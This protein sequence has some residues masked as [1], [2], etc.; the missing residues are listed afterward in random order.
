MVRVSPL[1]AIIESMSRRN[2]HKDHDFATIA[3]SVVEQ[4]IGEKLTGEPLQPSEKN[5]DAVARGKKGG[6]K[7]GKARAEALS[8]EQRTKIAKNAARKRW[9]GE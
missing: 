1:R 8:A 2:T 6:Q 9:G 4:A 7:G 3:R 5:P